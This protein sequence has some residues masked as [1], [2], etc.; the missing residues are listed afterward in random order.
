VFIGGSKIGL[1]PHKYAEQCAKTI[2]LTAGGWTSK[3]GKIDAVIEKVA[4]LKLNA[5][6]VIITDFMASSAYL[7]TN[8]DG[9]PIP[10]PKPCENNPT[11]L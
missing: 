4:Q 11:L 3:L 9:M 5:I 6:D 8:E 2:N 10:R 7:G 1:P